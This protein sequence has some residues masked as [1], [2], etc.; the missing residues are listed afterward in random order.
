MGCQLIAIAVFSCLSF[1]PAFS[2]SELIAATNL[3][4]RKMPIT[5][6]SLQA[7]HKEGSNVPGIP[8]TALMYCSPEKV[9]TLCLSPVRV[10][11][12]IMPMPYHSKFHKRF[13]LIL[14]LY[15]LEK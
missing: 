5:S 3:G 13:Y 9:S 12:R 2:F 11:E 10:F 1:L 6:L 15:M 7:D 14:C 8:A 4:H